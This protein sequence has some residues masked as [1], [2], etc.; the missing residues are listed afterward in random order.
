MATRSFLRLLEARKILVSHRFSELMPLVIA[1]CAVDQL[2][3]GRT[4]SS[5]HFSQG[6]SSHARKQATSSSHSTT[7]A[8]NYGHWHRNGYMGNKC[9]R[10][11]CFLDI[12]IIVHSA[13]MI[14]DAF[15][16]HKSW[17][18]TWTRYSPHCKTY[19]T[20]FMGYVLT[21]TGSR[22]ECYQNNMI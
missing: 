3:P 22:Q 12:C 6:L 9:G 4:K 18:L 8:Q 11:V 16:M 20:S 21:V 13:N 14:Q 17:P 1:E 15:P 19:I 10:R 2:L 7:G 5:G